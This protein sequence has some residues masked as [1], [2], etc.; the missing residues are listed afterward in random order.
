MMRQENGNKIAYIVVGVLFWPRRWEGCVLQV[1]V[2]HTGGY[3]KETTP[4]RPIFKARLLRNEEDI[5]IE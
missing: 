2:V 4:P 1:L 5:T 3:M